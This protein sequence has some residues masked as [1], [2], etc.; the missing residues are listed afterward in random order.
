MNANKLKYKWSAI[1]RFN[2]SSVW[3]QNILWLAV[4]LQFCFNFLR[5]HMNKVFTVCH[6]ESSVKSILSINQLQID[7]I[8]H[9]WIVDYSM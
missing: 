1:N 4:K 5:Y 7:K 8:N 3:S 9:R 2:F 6:V